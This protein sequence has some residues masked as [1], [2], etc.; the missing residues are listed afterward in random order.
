MSEP[1]VPQTR[2]RAEIRPDGAGVLDVNGTHRHI[3]PGPFP[4][5]RT[6]IVSHAAE[7]ASALRR[8]IGVTIGGADGHWDIVVHPDGAVTDVRQLEAPSPESIPTTPPLAD[9]Q[10]ATPQAF[11][12][13]AP[14]PQAPEPQAPAAA[15]PAQ[16]SAPTA[17]DAPAFGQT[18]TVPPL[19]D[20]TLASRD[21]LP[22]DDVADE[23]A[24]EAAASEPE[25]ATHGGTR[26]AHPRR[27]RG[28][29]RT[30]AGRAV[31]C[32][33]G[34]RQPT[35]RSSPATRPVRPAP[36]RRRC[37]GRARARRRAGRSAPRGRSPAAPSW[38]RAPRRRASSRGS[39][40]CCASWVPASR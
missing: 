38:R 14:E 18:G 33:R 30:R 23:P 5:T 1:I 20:A 10:A 17:S 19:A 26:A 22:Q 12:A 11:A 15:A 37:L 8:P 34:W 36:G 7:F 6:A 40:P 35:R 3:E 29:F 9:P 32:P 4:Q 25:P 2:I 24:Q 31:P 28:A 13:Q 21:E 39:C 27:P 16:A